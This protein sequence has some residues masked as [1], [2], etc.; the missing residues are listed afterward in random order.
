MK[1]DITLDY[2]SYFFFY[3]N[4]IHLFWFFFLYYE[5]LCS[6]NIF[7]S[8]LCP[9]FFFSERYA[10]FFFLYYCLHLLG[11]LFRHF[12]I[13]F[14]NSDSFFFCL[15]Y[16]L[17]FLVLFCLFLGLG[18]TISFELSECDWWRCCTEPRSLAFCILSYAYCNHWVFVFINNNCK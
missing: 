10:F 3:Y 9:T 14:A 17:N 2:P 4:V 15:H 16:L 5:N 12:S 11:L 6:L 18:A 7:R 1:H 13:L 8:S